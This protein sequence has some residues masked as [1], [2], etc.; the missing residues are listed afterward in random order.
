MQGFIDAGYRKNQLKILNFMRMSLRAISVADIAA[1]SGLTINHLAWELLQGNSLREHY[2]WPRD[3]PSFSKPQKELWKQALTKAF[4]RPHSVREHR[5]LS[6]PVAIWQSLPALEDCL[7]FYSQCE[8]RL[9]RKHDNSWKIYSYHSGG[10]RNRKYSFTNQTCA[11]K[12]T[13]ASLLASVSA[14]SPPDN[15]TD[16]VLVA[17]ECTYVWQYEDLDIDL[18]S[19]DPTEGPF[20]C[21]HDAFDS[22]IDSEKILLDEVKLPNDN[23]RAIATGIS[24]GTA[25]AISDGSY[26]PFTHK[27]TS[28]LIIVADKN[29][30]NPLDADNWVPGLPY[31]QSDYRSELAGV[32]GILSA[33][34]I[35]IQHY[36]ITSGSITIAL[37]GKSALDI[38]SAD[39][40]MKIE[41]PDFDLLQDIR[42]RLS[43]LPIT[44]NWRWVEGHQDKKG[45]SM[46]WWALQN[47]KLDLNAKSY[48][49]KCKNAKREHRPVLLLYKK[50]ALYVNG[51]K[52][53]KI[54]KNHSMQIC[55]PH[56]L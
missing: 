37:D 35:I 32:A 22:S 23:C 56:V 44:I 20:T 49:R 45:K 42:T 30:K 43:I 48:L 25:R 17:V 11:S 54:D 33:V 39:A 47:K 4:L 5:R 6:Q 15:S 36:N 38:A 19:Y 50:W 3:P 52:N 41:R 8:D 31:D 51:I 12:P 16:L 13:S 29:D 55:S 40:P 10:I 24:Q 21:I 28:S 46:D 1:S 7:Y 53:S 9:Y 26:D 2:D 18:S 27:G 34:S 14:R